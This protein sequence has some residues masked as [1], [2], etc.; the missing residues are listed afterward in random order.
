MEKLNKNNRILIV[1]AGAFGVALSNCILLNSNNLVTLL[2]R[3]DCVLFEEDITQYD[4]ILLAVPSQSLREAALWLKA[5]F[6][7]LNLSK[8]AKKIGIVSCAKGIEKNTILLP[9]QILEQIFHGYSVS[10]ASLSGPSFAKE[11]IKG[12]PTS[13]VLAS[14]DSLFLKK[15]SIILHSSCF[16]VYDSKDILGVEVGGALKNVIA[17]VAGAVDGLDLG[18]NARAAVITR[19][20]AE[21]ASIGVKMGANPLTFMGL[22]GVGDLILTCTGD[23]SRNRQFGF[24]LAKGE[25]KTSV[26]LALGGVIEGIDTAESAYT[27]AKKLNIKTGILMTAYHVLYQKLPIKDGVSSLLNREQ[28]AEFDI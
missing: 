7:K 26:L 3:K 24:R 27:L 5:Q 14:K 11:M 10:I 17:M 6:D 9:H 23:L 12:L 2:S 21:I 13:V 18:N 28:S 20:L 15:A 4:I 1:G 19:G 8:K 25:D 16:R 22:S